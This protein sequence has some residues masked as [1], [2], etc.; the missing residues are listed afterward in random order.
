MRDTLEKNAPPKTGRE[1]RYC[2]RYLSAYRRSAKLEG[3]RG[4]CRAEGRERKGTSETP[5]VCHE[6]Q[7]ARGHTSVG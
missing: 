3:K 1:C 7:A 5:G 6:R 4:R 2:R